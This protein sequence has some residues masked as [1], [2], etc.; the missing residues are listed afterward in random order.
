MATGWRC[1]EYLLS[2]QSAAHSP[3]GRNN[4][5]IGADNDGVVKLIV[6]RIF[7]ERERKVN[8]GFLFLVTLPLELLPN[9]W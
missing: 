8:V 6:N 5:A 3:Y 4:I 7:E 2:R 9:F 1:R